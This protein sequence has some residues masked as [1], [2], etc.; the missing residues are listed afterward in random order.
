MS[1]SVTMT[2][3]AA[4]ST[5]ELY[6]VLSNKSSKQNLGTYLRTASAFGATQ[7]IVVGT[8]RFGTHGAHR[9]HKYVDIVHFYKFEDA[10]EYLK[11]KGCEIVGVK[12]QPPSSIA[13][14]QTP[15]QGSTAFVID[16]EVPGLSEEQAAICDA[17]VHVPCHGAQVTPVS[18]D[19]TVVAAIVFYNFTKWAKFPA[20][21]MEATSTQGKFVLDAYPTHK[22]D[23]NKAAERAQKREFA[24]EDLADEFSRIFN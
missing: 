2:A 6:V 1:N 8:M 20:R 19:I 16:N 18:L 7:V 14:Q 17:F 4:A 21:S 12:T 15:F 5:P 22:K 10:C 24:D 13:A 9:A 3:A 11:S 23:E